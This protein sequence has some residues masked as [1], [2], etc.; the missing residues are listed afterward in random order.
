MSIEMID[1]PVSTRTGPN[2]R[3]HSYKLPEVYKPLA[4]KYGEV[5]K[6]RKFSRELVDPQDFANALEI[7][8]TDCRFDL[9]S[10]MDVFHCSRATLYAMLQSKEFA[11]LYEAAKE[12]RADAALKRGWDVTEETYYGAMNGDIGR[13]AVNA[14]KN[15]ANYSLAYAQ[16]ISSRYGKKGENEGLNVQIAVPQFSNLDNGPKPEAA[17]VVEAEV[18]DSGNQ[19]A[20]N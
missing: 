12:S 18:V 16:L 14:A 9:Y 13:D 7:Y 10:L 11:P 2:S 20:E 15:L 5:F 17:A 3:V 4:A 8:A 6:N 1:G 19:R